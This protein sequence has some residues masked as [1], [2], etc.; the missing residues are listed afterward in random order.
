MILRE[1]GDGVENMDDVVVIMVVR[2]FEV[3]DDKYKV[4]RSHMIKLKVEVLNVK[5]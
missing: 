1:I 3:K 2:K 5:T 4:I